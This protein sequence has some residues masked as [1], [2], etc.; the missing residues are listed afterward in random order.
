[1]KNNKLSKLFKIWK[2]KQTILEGYMMI[3][4]INS[5]MN[6]VKIKKKIKLINKRGRKSNIQNFLFKIFHSFIYIHSYEKILRYIFL[7]LKLTT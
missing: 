5:L 2:K 4:Q 1:M 7:N 3:L 6:L